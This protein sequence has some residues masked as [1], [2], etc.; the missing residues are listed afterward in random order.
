[1][2]DREVIRYIVVGIGVI[3]LMLFGL[4]VLSNRIVNIGNATGVLISA[5][6]IGYGIY[7]NRVNEILNNIWNKTYGRVILCILEFCIAAIITMAVGITILIVHANMQKTQGNTTLIVL[8]CKVNGENP[9]LMLTERL[10]AAYEYLVEHEDVICILS[11][12]KGDDEDISEAECMYR[13]L[14]DKGIS[15]ERL[16]KEDKSTSTRENLAFSKEIIEEYN[17]S[18]NIT[19]VTNE[20]HQYRARRVAEKLG[21]NVS[22]ISGKTAWWLFPTYYVRELYGVLYELCFE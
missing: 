20:F 15:A 2:R 16:I 7:M 22:A 12:G 3:A 13:Y 21:F 14:V 19:I 4:P 6:L 8:G 5:M 1:M 9:S 18:T 17:F 11:G 10:D